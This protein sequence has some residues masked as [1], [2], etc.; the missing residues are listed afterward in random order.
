VSVH[1]IYLQHVRRD[2]VTTDP[3]F[4]CYQPKLPVLCQVERTL[5]QSVTLQQSSNVVLTQVIN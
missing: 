5:T 3:L 2:A 1:L 4:L